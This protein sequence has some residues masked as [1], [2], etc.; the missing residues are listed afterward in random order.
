MRGVRAGL[1][2]LTLV[3]VAPPVASSGLRIAELVLPSSALS[4]VE[5][6]PPDTAGLAALT[7][8]ELFV[9]ASS[10]ELQFSELVRPSRRLL[11][12]DHERTLPYL[13]SV[14][15]TDG[16]R[17]RHALEDILVS[18]GY[19]AVEP[20]IAGL[21]AE[22]ANEESTRGVRMAVRT[23]GMIGDPSATAALA[24][25]AAHPDWKVRG[26]AAGALGR[27]GTARSLP[28]LRNLLADGNEIVRTGAAV[29]MRRVAGNSG[30]GLP[31]A[32]VAAL[33]EAL[34][35]DYYAVRMSA[36]SALAA[37]GDVAVER[38][39]ERAR[40]PASSGGRLAVKALGGIG[41]AKTKR[42]LRELLA[43]DDW[44]V[45]AYAA[46]GLGQERLSARTKRA[47]VALASDEK[48]PFVRL[49]IERALPGE[50]VSP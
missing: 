50:G 19:P 34:D 8:E 14:L 25:A 16:A 26:S 7:P 15:G 17:E 6:A 13:V 42:I 22:L 12:R 23:L 20:L 30:E 32:I 44:V 36:V 43:S 31:D 4:A 9:R 11:I 48:H 35:D 18:I 1:V 2:F 3:L 5:A 40:G 38:L 37:A 33:V 29:G 46:E 27:I 41:G 10:A 47:L 28:E 45:R 21:E 39:V 24:G 49:M